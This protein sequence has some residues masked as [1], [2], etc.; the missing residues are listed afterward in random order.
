ML[1]NNSSIVLKNKLSPKSIKSGNNP[2]MKFFSSENSKI[3]K[4]NDRYFLSDK[5]IKKVDIR[6]KKTF[7]GMT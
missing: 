6:K 1:S 4:K 2:S 3:K 7:D 5:D